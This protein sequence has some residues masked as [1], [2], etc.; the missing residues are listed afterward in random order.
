MKKDIIM[1]PSKKKFQV[2]D[3]MVLWAEHGLWSQIKV[4]VNTG[5]GIEVSS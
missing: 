4:A 1:C 5:I 2:R 3:S